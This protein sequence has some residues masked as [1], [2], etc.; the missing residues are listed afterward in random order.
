M[1]S[2]RSLVFLAFSAECSA[3]RLRDVPLG[4]CGEC[5]VNCF[6]DCAL[7]FDREIMQVDM[8]VQTGAGKVEKH[9]VSRSKTK[10]PSVQELS[11][12][13]LSIEMGRLKAHKGKTCPKKEGCALAKTCAKNIDAELTSLE[14]VRLN[15]QADLRTMEEDEID[16]GRELG[17]KGKDWTQA[18]GTMVTI[19]DIPTWNAP[20]PSQ[21]KMTTHLFIE[22]NATKRSLRG[23]L[24]PAPGTGNDPNDPFTYYPAHPV[25]IGI[26][27]KGR[28][29]LKMC[30]DF[31]LS[32]TCGCEGVP[33]M[34][35]KKKMD[36]F[37]DAGAKAG[38][39]TVTPPVW[40]YR[41]AKK[42]ECGNGLGD[43]KVIKDL[44]VDFSPGV[45]GWIEVCTKKFFDTSY[46]AAAALGMTD[47]T[48]DLEKCA[49]GVDRL[50]CH[51]PKYGCSWNN[52]KQRC[53]YK[54]MHNTVCF[55]RYTFDL[56]L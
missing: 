36:K 33:G 27:S 35:D 22:E 28:Q 21:L 10:A 38:Y 25:K 46:G 19:S 45:D 47:A 54:A 11:K 6:E 14:A 8:L 51:E 52:I 55:K 40:K 41:K 50:D 13:A 39:H 32:T 7:K 5:E 17:E 15:S 26:F 1:V 16:R 4:L 20:S 42:E 44:Y 2:A 48:K 18:S 30:M 3:S 23:N 31:C 37:A 34:E 53:E 56:G 24:A 9:G 12:R 49:C 29:T 43:N